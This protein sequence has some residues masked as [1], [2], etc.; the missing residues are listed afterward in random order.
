MWKKEN[1]QMRWVRKRVMENGIW[2]E[3]GFGFGF[4]T[5]LLRTQIWSKARQSER[6]SE[7]EPN[8]K[9]SNQAHYCVYIY[10]EILTFKFFKEK[11]RNWWESWSSLRVSSN[12]NFVFVL[13]VWVIFVINTIIHFYMHFNLTC[14][15]VS[16]EEKIMDLTVRASKL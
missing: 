11:V 3:K 1:K 6:G 15:I 14:Q 2:D 16:C 8:A 9:Q 12:I 13:I 5:F 10:S 7:W 4:R